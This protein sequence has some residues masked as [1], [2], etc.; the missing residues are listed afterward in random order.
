M[1]RV[2]C[3]RPMNFK[4]KFSSRQPMKQRLNSLGR[5]TC[6]LGYG[7]ENWL[8]RNC[9][10][11]G[12]LSMFVFSGCWF[13][14][15]VNFEA[16]EILDVLLNQ[17]LF[18]WLEIWELFLGCVCWEKLKLYSY[19]WISPKGATHQWVPVLMLRTIQFCTIS[20]GRDNRK[21]L[22]SKLF[23]G[24]K[25]QWAHV[26]TCFKF[27]AELSFNWEWLSNSKSI[28]G[29]RAFTRRK[30]WKWHATVHHNMG[31]KL[32][33]CQHFQERQGLPLNIWDVQISW[34][35]KRCR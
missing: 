12:Y 6:W 5:L 31:V 11:V 14:K 7:T 3:W 20:G 33:N 2:Y 26:K 23:G 32:H 13:K 4:K 15:I 10:L 16:I 21:H 28:P 29:L 1:F 8:T 34:T 35:A 27:Q 18:T 19:Q 9:G 17:P 30:S 24:L 25:A 22:L